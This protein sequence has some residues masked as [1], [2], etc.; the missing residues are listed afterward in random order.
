M[1]KRGCP[2]GAGNY[3]QEDLKALLDAVQEELPLGQHGWQSIHAKYIK[4]ARK[5]GRPKRAHKSL[6]TKYKQVCQLMHQFKYALT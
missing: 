2:Q 6:E 5:R 1:M 3:L 4:L